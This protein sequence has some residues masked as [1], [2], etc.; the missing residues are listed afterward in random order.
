MACNTLFNRKV[1]LASLLAIGVAGSAQAQG[2]GN[3]VGG[4][5]ASISGGGEDITLTSSSGGA[6]GGAR[7]EQVGRSVTFA[8]NSGDSPSWTYG[9]APASGPGLAAWTIG[10]GDDRQVV[11]VSPYQRG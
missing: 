11:Y 5:G 6:G 9:S 2:I 3:V 10:G 8:G 1:I 7:Y 4:G